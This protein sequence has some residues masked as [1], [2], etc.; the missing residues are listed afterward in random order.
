MSD[1]QIWTGLS[2]LISGFSQLSCGISSYHWLLLVCLAWFS[3]LTQLA[4]LTM[5]RNYLYNR[6]AERIWRLCAMGVF[7]VLLIVA[8]IP[9]GHFGVRQNSPYE[10]ALC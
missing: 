10:Y 6:P 4:C 5:L 1:I 9:A 3:S 2:I 7:A 8:Y